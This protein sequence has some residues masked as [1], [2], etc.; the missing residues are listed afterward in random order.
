[1]PAAGRS[2]A[3][4]RPF[5][6]EQLAVAYV[7][8]AF[9]NETVSL[10]RWHLVTFREVLA[11]IFAHDADLGDSGFELLRADTEGFRPVPDFVGF[12]NVY[13]RAIGRSA[14]FEVVCHTVH[15]GRAEWS[16][17]WRWPERRTVR[18]RAF[19]R[20]PREPLS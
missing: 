6:H 5:E 12:V 7:G 2:D 9:G 14:V 10:A 16:A 13:A 19:A 3:T 18:C 17:M 8:C 20:G 1:M 4:A 11:H 15:L